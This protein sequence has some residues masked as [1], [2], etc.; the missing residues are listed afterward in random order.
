[1]HKTTLCACLFFLAQQWSMAQVTGSPGEDKKPPEITK[2]AFRRSEC[3][4]MTQAERLHY[5]F[6]STF[7]LE[8]ALRSA[9]GA[10]ISQLQNTPSE[11]GP[12][13]EGYSKRL[14]NSYRQH[15]MRATM[16]YGASSFLHDDTRAI[17]PA[18]TASD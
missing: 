4:P 12:G 2:A 7:G 10:G 15:L 6:R 18:A 11:G 16:L 13:A 14:G 5:Y 17:P 1:M 9:A 3:R 8:A